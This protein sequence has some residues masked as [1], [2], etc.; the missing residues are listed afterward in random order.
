MLLVGKEYFFQPDSR[1][2]VIHEGIDLKVVFETTEVYVGRAYRGYVVINDKRFGMQESPLVKQ[3]LY[4]CL[5]D[6][7]KV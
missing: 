2:G 3:Y 1:E 6:I 7:T 5:H 4:T